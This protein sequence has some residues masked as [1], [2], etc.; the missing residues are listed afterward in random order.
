MIARFLVRV[1]VDWQLLLTLIAALP[2]AGN[3]FVLAQKCETYVD[4]TATA[5]VMPTA[6]SL[7]TL[8]LLIIII[9]IEVD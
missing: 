8:T 7:L 4:R 1:D 5:F 2:M 3:V 9:S 6:F